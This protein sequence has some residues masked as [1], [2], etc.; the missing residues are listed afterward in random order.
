MNRREFL[1]VGAAGLLLPVVEPIRRYWSLDRTMIF[2]PYQRFAD[3]TGVPV[4][5]LKAVMTTGWIDTRWAPYTKV[6]SHITVGDD[7]LYLAGTPEYEAIINRYVG[8]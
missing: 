8:R 2:D 3:A 4:N 6:P 7:V 1:K 5:L